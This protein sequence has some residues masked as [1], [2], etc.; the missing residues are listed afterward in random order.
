V[1]LPTVNATA[2]A[3]GHYLTHPYP[4]QSK[5]LAGDLAISLERILLGF[6]IGTIIGVA[7]GAAM[8]VNQFIRQLI[9]PIIEVIMLLPPLAFIPLFIVWFGSVDVDRGGR[10]AGRHQRRGLPDQPVDPSR[11]S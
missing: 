10:D 9:D 1:A 7:I 3:F 5:T 4:S 11:R 8:S 6:A 2:H